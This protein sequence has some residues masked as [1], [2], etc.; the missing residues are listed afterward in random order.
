MLSIYSSAK[1]RKKTHTAKFVVC[2]LLAAHYSEADGSP[3]KFGWGHG[4]PD[5]A[6]HRGLDARRCL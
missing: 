1:L 4:R 2:F 6:R 5:R 3:I